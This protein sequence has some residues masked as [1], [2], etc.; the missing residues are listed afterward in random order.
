[1]FGKRYKNNLIE[2]THGEGWLV[3]LCVWAPLEPILDKT[4]RS[5]DI[6]RIK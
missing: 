3:G 4:S 2:T 1:M 6:E 5:N